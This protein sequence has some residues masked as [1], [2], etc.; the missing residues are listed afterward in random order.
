ME[1]GG[2]GEEALPMAR[3]RVITRLVL[4]QPGLHSYDMS[5]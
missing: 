3:D 5:G 2:G 1:E 4:L